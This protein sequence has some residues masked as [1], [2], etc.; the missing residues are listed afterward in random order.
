MPVLVVQ[1]VVTSSSPTN[2]YIC[3]SVFLNSHFAWNVGKNVN[4]RKCWENIQ[5]NWLEGKYS[6]RLLGWITCG[7]TAKSTILYCRFIRVKDALCKLHINTSLA[8]YMEV[9]CLYCS[10]V[11]IGKAGRCMG[12]L[13][14]NWADFAKLQLAA[15]MR[16]TLSLLR[17]HLLPRGCQL[18]PRWNCFSFSR[19]STGTPA[20]GTCMPEDSTVGKLLACMCSLSAARQVTWPPT[21]ESTCASIASRLGVLAPTF[22]SAPRAL[23]TLPQGR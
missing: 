19:E 17:V 1:V 8:K 21:A 6:K 7:R 13:S 4:Y 16:Q 12:P 3:V 20:E 23:A 10:K 2:M 15:P 5:C 14:R 9:N 18:H 11:Q 22:P